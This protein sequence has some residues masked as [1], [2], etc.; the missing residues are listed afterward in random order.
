MMVTEDRKRYGLVLDESIAFNMSLANLAEFMEYGLVDGNQEMLADRRYADRLQGYEPGFFNSRLFDVD[1]TDWDWIFF[2]LMDPQFISPRNITNLSIELA[3][4]AVLALGMLLVLLPGDIDL[5]VWQ[6]SWAEG[7]NRQCTYI[8]LLVA[9]MGCDA[10]IVGCSRHP[11]VFD[12][13]F[14]YQSRSAVFY[15]YAW[16]FVDLQRTVLDDHQ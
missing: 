15:H 8:F 7:R 4:T 3:I 6:R 14:D 10:C 11:L 16:W 5:S 9:G 2:S 13:A 1:R 12:G